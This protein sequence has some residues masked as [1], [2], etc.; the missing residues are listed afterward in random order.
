MKINIYQINKSRDVNRVAFDGL[1]LL[2]KLHGQN[3]VDRSIY[4]KVFSGE[5]NCKDLEDVYRM[6]NLE[7]PWGYTGRSL[8]VSD[9]VEVVDSPNLVGRIDYIETGMSSVY[10][11]FLEYT[12]QQE[13]LREEDV[14][15]EAHDYIGLRIPS[16]EKGFYFCDS[17][18]FKKIDFRIHKDISN[19][20]LSLN[21]QIAASA[22][23]V[24]RDVA[25]SVV[26]KE[27]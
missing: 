17:I 13:K 16:V 24:K 21:D 5:V 3:D 25:H 11:D 8:S 15:F 10:T 6:F 1:E 2:K 23:Q 27:R 20:K 19:E 9:V 4:D 7:H 14:D 12:L 22:S 26:D 18:G